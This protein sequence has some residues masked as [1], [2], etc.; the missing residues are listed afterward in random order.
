MS[1]LRSSFTRKWPVTGM[2]SPFLK[3][4]QIKII[5]SK[6][7]PGLLL[8]RRYPLLRTNRGMFLLVVGE[9]KTLPFY[10]GTAYS[11]CSMEDIEISWLLC[12]Q[13]KYTAQ[14]IIYL[15]FKTRALAPLQIPAS[16][17][18]GPIYLLLCWVVILLEKAPVREHHFHL[19]AL[20]LIDT[21]YDHDWISFAMNYNVQSVLD[22]QGCSAF[23][24]CGLRKG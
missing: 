16:L 22:L 23:M 5:A 7:P 10:L 13:W 11:V 24:F 21:E 9:Y 8:V 12:W 14:N 1:G 19:Y 3:E 17:C 15:Y 20:L 6:T 18:E 2:P 4:N